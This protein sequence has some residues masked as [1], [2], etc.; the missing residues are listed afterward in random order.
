MTAIAVSSVTSLAEIG[1]LDTGLLLEVGEDSDTFQEGSFTT[2]DV[3]AILAQE[4]LDMMVYTGGILS[5]LSAV[6]DFD[7]LQHNLYKIDRIC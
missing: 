6:N 1:L 4:V 3:L 5:M 2:T 7:E